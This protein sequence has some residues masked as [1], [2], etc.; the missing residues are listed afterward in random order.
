MFTPSE[1][2]TLKHIMTWEDEA[3]ADLFGEELMK[4]FK[5]KIAKVTRRLNHKRFTVYSNEDVISKYQEEI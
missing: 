2:E 4:M 5:E 1:I 3:I